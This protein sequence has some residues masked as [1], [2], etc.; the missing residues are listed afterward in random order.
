MAYI[1]LDAMD[2]YVPKLD[3]DT[4]DILVFDDKYNIINNV[5]FYN[6]STI[7]FAVSYSDIV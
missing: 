6:S 7:Y 1:Y 5:N 4:D 2:E 3:M